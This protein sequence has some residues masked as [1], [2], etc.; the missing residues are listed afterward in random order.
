MQTEA[1]IRSIAGK[2][3]SRYKRWLAN[4]KKENPDFIFPTLEKETAKNSQSLY[5][6]TQ[7]TSMIISD[8][9]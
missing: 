5:P 8:Y 4:F 6:E 7:L 1:E 3:K 9:G 2:R